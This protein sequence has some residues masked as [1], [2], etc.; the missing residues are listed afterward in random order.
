MRL[1]AITDVDSRDGTSNKD[2]R[3]V[4]MLAE[5]DGQVSLATIRPAINTVVAGSG[6]GKG[7]TCFN[8]TNLAVLGTTLYRGETPTSI[9]TVSGTYFDFTQ[10]P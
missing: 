5:K 7:M 9:G 6:A 8:S 1:Q 2:E 10:I 4:N 3:L